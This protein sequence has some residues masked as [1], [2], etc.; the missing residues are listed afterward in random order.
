MVVKRVRGVCGR[1]NVATAIQ[2]M[3]RGGN[4]CVVNHQLES[5]PNVT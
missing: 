3:N 1:N 5:G 2:Q 4:R